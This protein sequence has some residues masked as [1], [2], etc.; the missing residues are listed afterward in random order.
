[1]IEISYI[2]QCLISRYNVDK[3]QAYLQAC[4]FSFYEAE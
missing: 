4:L 2:E 3:I 1:M